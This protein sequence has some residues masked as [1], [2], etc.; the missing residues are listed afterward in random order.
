MPP[1]GHR[2]VEVSPIITF[3]DARIRANHYAGIA[4]PD[5]GCRAAHQSLTWRTQ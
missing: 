3:E 2:E 1:F 4:A 5:L